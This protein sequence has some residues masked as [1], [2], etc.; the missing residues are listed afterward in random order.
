MN[1]SVNQSG[2]SSV[3]SSPGAGAFPPT[4]DDDFEIDPL[5][6]ASLPSSL[7]ASASVSIDPSDVVCFF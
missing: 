3:V 1:S 7:S 6:T 4:P 2:V 5:I